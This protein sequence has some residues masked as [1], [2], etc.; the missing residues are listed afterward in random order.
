MAQNKALHPR[1]ERKNEEED[2]PALRNALMHQYKD[3]RTALKSAKKEKLLQP[4]M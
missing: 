4:I 2:S 3:L 1:N